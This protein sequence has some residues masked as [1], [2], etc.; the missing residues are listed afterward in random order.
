M[1]LSEKEEQIFEKLRQYKDSRKISGEEKMLQSTIQ[2]LP[3]Q[4]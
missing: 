1:G 2:V 4:V 3:P